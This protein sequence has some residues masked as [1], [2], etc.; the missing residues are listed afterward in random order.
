MKVISRMLVLMAFAL[1]T[2][3]KAQDWLP[4]GAD[5]CY[6]TQYEDGVLPDATFR[7]KAKVTKEEFE[8]IVKKIGAT[9]HTET[10]KYTDDKAWLNWSSERGGD[11]KPLK[12][13]KNWD[14]E[15]DLSSTFV[16]Q[17]NDSWQFLKFEGG[18]LYYVALNH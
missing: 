16:L 8:T 18:F 11:L 15:D 10:R 7:L 1:V 6:R 9:L 17:K 13:R 14:P 2:Q 3:S 12:G 5:V 4:K